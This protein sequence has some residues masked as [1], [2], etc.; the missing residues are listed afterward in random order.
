MKLRRKEIGE[1]GEKEKTIQL[2]L[3]VPENHVVC[4]IMEEFLES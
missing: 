3:L 4:P 2:T 1:K